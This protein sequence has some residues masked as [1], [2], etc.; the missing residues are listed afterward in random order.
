MW[1]KRTTNVIESTYATSLETLEQGRFV[2][3]NVF[4]CA[5]G[6]ERTALRP[7]QLKARHTR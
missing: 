3:T 5:S 2:E 7:A 6:S 1:G 4:A